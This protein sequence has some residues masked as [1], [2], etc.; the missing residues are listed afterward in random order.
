MRDRF[1]GD[2]TRFESR[3]QHLIAVCYQA[4]AICRNRRSLRDRQAREGLWCPE[5]CSWLLAR[6]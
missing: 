6:W 1:G 4:P 2:R 5:V 3:I